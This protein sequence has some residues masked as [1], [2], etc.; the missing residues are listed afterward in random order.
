M[1]SFHPD[2][3][4]FLRALEKHGE[5]KR[6]SVEVDPELEITEIASRMVR[7]EGPAL[8]FEKVKGSPFPLAINFFGNARRIEIALG[9]TPRE[10][11]E[12]LV[13][14]AHALNPPRLR[15]LWKSRRTIRRLLAAHATKCRRGPC[16]EV[17]T[18]PA[19]DRLPVLKCWPKDG[20]RFIT[21]GLVLTRHPV[22]GIRNV[23]LYRLQV[24]SPSLTGMHWQIERGGGF[25]YEEA[26]KRDQPLPAA[27]V[28]GT[29]PYLMMAS[30]APLPEDMDEVAFSGFLRGRPMD[31]V[32]TAALPGFDVP[33]NADFILEGEIPP[34]ERQLEGPFGDHLGHYSLAAPFPVFHVRKM[35]HRKNAV[36]PAA[37][38]GKPP[39]ED[40]YL[41]DA[42]QEMFIPLIKLLRP[43]VADLWAYY[44]VGFHNLL[45]VSV[46]Q[47]YVKES[48]KTA[49]GILGE[50]QLSLTKC[51]VL[52]DHHVNVRDFHAV[53]HA[54]RQ[55]MDVSEDVAI[56]PGVPLDTLDFTSY[57]M[58]LGS[59]LIID[60]TRRHGSALPKRPPAGDVF[61]LDLKRKYPEIL[62][63]RCWDGTLLVVQTAK[64]G[65][66]LLEKLVRDKS[67]E[68]VKIAAVV[69]PDVN[70]ENRESMMWGL[71][72]RFDCARDVIFSGTHLTGPVA[73]YAGTMGIDATHKPGYPEPVE[74]SQGIIELV[75]RRWNEYGI[76]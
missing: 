61:D 32:K 69:S 44:E 19:L 1:T 73:R 49:L 34:Q 56:L 66:A 17:V 10:A 11:G 39:Q 51:L 52:V 38:V 50:G 65:R 36:Y 74:M 9:R 25:H 16:Q 64:E 57:T 22:T 18:E 70:I 63:W 58:N 54:I 21:F 41:G 68:G 20:G 6:V 2:F 42:L 5:L 13:R 12:E 37:I 72:N 29:D 27:I 71:F 30:V 47:R 28:I 35:T 46:N 48:M 14:M 31:M 8:L 3:R 23:G 15:G 26:E 45:V 76:R 67:L 62:G 55:N 75:N 7:E 4:S 53:L 59:K 43:E 33:A 24:F 60:A 40:R